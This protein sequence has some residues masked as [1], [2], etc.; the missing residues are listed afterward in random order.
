MNR[1]FT[2]KIIQYPIT[3]LKACWYSRIIS[4]LRS[5]SFSKFP[6][7]PTKQSVFAVSCSPAF[8]KCVTIYFKMWALEIIAVSVLLI[9]TRHQGLR[10]VVI[11]TWY[12]VVCFGKVWFARAV[13]TAPGGAQS[14]KRLTVEWE[15]AGSIPGTG[16]ALK[17]LI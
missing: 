10:L 1:K 7:I 17:V 11:Y 4:I 8:D 13:Y 12:H 5:L 14:I 16:P 2:I 15:V 3:V 6:I 9:T